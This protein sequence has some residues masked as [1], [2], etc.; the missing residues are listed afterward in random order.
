MSSILIS[1]S[2]SKNDHFK[3]SHISNLNQDTINCID[4][5]KDSQDSTILFSCSDQELTLCNLNTLV[6]HSLFPTAGSSS[7]KKQ[8]NEFNSLKFHQ[9]G[10]D[11]NY[12]FVSNDNIL[13]LYDVNAL[14]QTST[15]KFCQDT[16]NSI[17]INSQNSLVALADDAGEI[18]LLDLRTNKD[19]KLKSSGIS[20]TLKKT[21]KQHSNIC[22]CLQFNPFNPNELFSGSFDCSVIKWD[23]RFA[24]KSSN[25]FLSKIDLTSTL[26]SLNESSF[27]SNMTPNFVH[28]ILLAKNKANNSNV[29]LCGIENGFCVLFDSN[30]CKYLS[31]QQLQS[32]N[33][34]LTQFEELDNF[35][36]SDLKLEN[37]AINS[38]NNLIAA[39]GDGKLIEFICLAD[40]NGTSQINA[41]KELTI[42]HSSKINCLK[43]D[44]SAN[45]DNKNRRIFVADTS[46]NVSFYDFSR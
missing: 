37:N 43:I 29:L 44:Q 45:S 27:Y 21:F 30:T 7:K 14:K 39:A 8:E 4:I 40:K 41:I 36:V 31:H 26:A 3:K 25:S 17:E 32:P 20:L 42:N 15:F 38:S 19:S 5:Q 10:K 13:N 9:F 1:E 11:S 2:T 28:K 33:C 23:L 6:K 22:F 24:N 16:I 12:L 35:S 34:A 46:N 18:K